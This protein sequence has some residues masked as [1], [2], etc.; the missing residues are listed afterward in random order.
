MGQMEA[1]APQSAR[2]LLAMLVAAGLLRVH[3][4]AP[5][6]G[7][8]PPTIFRASHRTEMP[9]PVRIWQS[10]PFAVH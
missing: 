10:L 8:G 5:P 2:D 7:H 4:A 6:A 1:L 9:S 3:T